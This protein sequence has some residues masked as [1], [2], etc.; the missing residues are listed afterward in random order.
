MA[1]RVQVI[2][3]SDLSG[4]D[5]G[6]GGQTVKFGVNNASYEIDLS[7]D[8]VGELFT[9]LKPYIDN[10]T[11]TSGRGVRRSRANTPEIDPKAVRAWAA[12]NNVEV[13]DRGRIPADVIDKYKAAGN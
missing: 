11:K 3:I 10:A 1:Q 6:D 9:V 5:L 7:D 2:R 12:A 13:N 8:E 4:A